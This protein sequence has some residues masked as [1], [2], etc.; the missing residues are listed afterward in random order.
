MKKFGFSRSK[1]KSDKGEKSSSPANG[2]PYAAQSTNDSYTSAPPAYSGSADSFRQEKT[3]VPAGGY[4]SAQADRYAPGASS[5]GYGSSRYG[6]PSDAEQAPAPSR[7]GNSGYGGFGGA[8][9]TTSRYGGGSASGP[10]VQP[11]R[12]GGGPAE[13]GLPA[14]PSRYGQPPTRYGQQSAM[15]TG[16]EQDSAP[17]SDWQSGTGPDYGTN[18]GYGAYEDRQLT[19]EEQEGK[20]FVDTDLYTTLALADCFLE[21]DI[22][23]AKGEIKFLK[24]S[25]VSSTRNALR[26]A[27]QAEVGT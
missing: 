16:A 17:Q 3:P 15:A 2:N 8:P 12:Y 1:D 22:L 20:F 9:D 24:Q 11:S 27:A 5:G 14:Q 13:G 26:I 10:P 6:A 25:D 7:Y 4:G 23:A 18:Q 19:A 21:E